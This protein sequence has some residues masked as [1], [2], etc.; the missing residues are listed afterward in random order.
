LTFASHTI[1]VCTV[2]G[3]D[4]YAAMETKLSTY[5]EQVHKYEK[6]SQSTDVSEA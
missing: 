5:T 1:V 4:A 3:S 6:I 2:L